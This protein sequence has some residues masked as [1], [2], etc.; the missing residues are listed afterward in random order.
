MGFYIVIWLGLLLTCLIRKKLAVVVALWWVVLVFIAGGRDIDVGVDTITYRGLFYQIS[1]GDS[2]SWVE[3]LWRLLNYCVYKWLSNDFNILLVVVAIITLSNIFF[4]LYKESPNFYYSLFVF[5]SLH[6]YMASFNIT[7]QYVAM[8]FI[9]LS[10][11]YYI[12]QKKIGAITA[13]AVAIGF[14]YSSLFVL[15]AFLFYKLKLTFGRIL[16]LIIISIVFG[17]IMNKSLMAFFATS[18]YSSFTDYDT[19]FRESGFITYLFV[20]LQNILAIYIIKLTKDSLYGSLW[21]KLFVFSI[22]VF[23]ITFMVAYAARIY[24]VFAISQIVFFPVFLKQIKPSDRTMASLLLFSYLST[25][26]FRILLANGNQIIPYKN[27]RT[28]SRSF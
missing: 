24:S 2:P 27:G 19:V 11:F 9:L 21:F 18:L 20:L 7:R 16:K 4:V 5:Y 15:P 14:H 25:Q 22:I 1:S 28:S 12:H 23:N 10:C 8:S 17:S 13:M 3:P 6:M 26:F